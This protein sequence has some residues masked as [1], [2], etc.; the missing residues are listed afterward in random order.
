[1][2][3]THINDNDDVDSDDP[4]PEDPQ[5]AQDLADARASG[6][7]ALLSRNAIHDRSRI[8]VVT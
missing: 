4:E 8:I 7:A 3:R 2:D 5:D 1:M 6:Q